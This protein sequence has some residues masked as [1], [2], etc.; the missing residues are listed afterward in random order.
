M[1]DTLTI[2]RDVYLNED[3]TI[4][5]QIIENEFIYEYLIVEYWVMN[6]GVVTNTY[7]T[8]DL[9]DDMNDQVIIFNVEELNQVNDL[10][11]I[12]EGE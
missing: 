9:P 10:K 5:N 6:A 8:N 11:S 4:Y 2:L 1:N 3:A 7:F 12:I